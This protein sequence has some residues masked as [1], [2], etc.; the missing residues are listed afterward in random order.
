MS[1]DPPRP[2]FETVEFRTEPD[3][4][5]TRLDKL[6]AALV[7]DKALPLSRT[8]LQTLIVDGHV[9]L[10]GTAV[11]DGGQK[12]RGTADLVLR[13]PPPEDPV[14]APEAISLDIVYEDGDLLVL[15][16]P[17]GLV[18]HPA[19]GH[20]TGT[21]VNALLAHCG[22]GLSGIGGVRRPGIVH[23]L[24]KDTTGLMVVAKNDR[25]HQGLADIF[26]DHGRSGSLVREYL[27][28]AW[29]TPQ[30]SSGRIDAPLGRHPHH[31]DKMAVVSAAKGR[32]AVTHWSVEERFGRLASCIRCRLETGRTHQIRV[33]LAE[34]GHPLIGDPVYGPGFRTKALQIAE[35]GRSVVQSLRRQALHAATLGFDHP[36]TGETLKFDSALP[37]DLVG[38]SHALRESS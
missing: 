33:H 12:V 28:F 1:I 13:L 18:V 15:D 37:A 23:R 22:D 3:L 38:L 19:A 35:P 30:A 5:A 24:D 2:V 32:H 17:A 27:A 6:L 11:L 14:P 29:M 16:K 21:L 26:A 31:R 36:I 9:S 20:E 8:R 34:I 10:D 25:A 7:R 4:P